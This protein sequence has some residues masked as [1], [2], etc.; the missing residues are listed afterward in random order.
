MIEFVAETSWYIHP[1]GRVCT[2]LTKA[3]AFWAK[4]AQGK[5]RKLSPQEV[6][7][8]MQLARSKG[9]PESFRVEWDVNNECKKWIAVSYSLFASVQ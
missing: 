2:T 1:D 7:T 3:L 4:I 5:D 9:L 8:A 6:D